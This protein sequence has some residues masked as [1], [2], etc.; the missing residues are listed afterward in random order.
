MVEGQS[1]AKVDGKTEA[2]GKAKGYKNTD[3]STDNITTGTTATGNVNPIAPPVKKFYHKQDADAVEEEEFV[4]SVPVIPPRPLIAP[5]LPIKPTSTAKKTP[6]KQ[7]NSYPREDNIFT[8][9][10]PELLVNKFYSNA[11]LT[12]LPTDFIP[13]VF[14]NNKEDDNAVIGLQYGKIVKYSINES[15]STLDNFLDLSPNNRQ[16]YE[17]IQV[18]MGT[19]LA[20]QDTGIVYKLSPSDG[21]L[22]ILLRDAIP[23]G[24]TRVHLRPEINEIWVIG[25]RETSILAVNKDK[26]DVALVKRIPTQFPE[27]ASVS[28][29]DAEDLAVLQRDRTVK[30]FSLPRFGHAPGLIA[31]IPAVLGGDLVKIVKIPSGIKNKNFNYYATIYSDGKMIIWK[32][33]VNEQGLTETIT[34]PLTL[35]RIQTAHLSKNFLW[36]GLN[37]GKIIVVQVTADFQQIVAEVKS[38]QTTVNKFIKTDGSGLVSIDSGGQ[39]CLWDENLTVYQQSN[40]LNRNLF[41]YFF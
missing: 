3:N 22:K 7:S 13:K 39:L 34:I 30:I 32:F 20:F 38:H 19:L 33:Q 29:L 5:K 2:D 16:F 37:N 25:L 31:N 10:K 8:G 23:M 28:F 18:Q 35:F 11:L 6:V 9:L 14:V 27:A 41:V 21:Q 26:N 15:S 1:K 40:E 4:D 36:L 12:T 24:T 17:L